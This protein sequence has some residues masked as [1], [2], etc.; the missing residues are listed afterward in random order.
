MSEW[1]TGTGCQ[2]GSGGR[3]RVGRTVWE[4]ITSGSIYCKQK[5]GDGPG[6]CPYRVVV[7]DLQVPWPLA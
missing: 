7:E 6:H 5:V 4:V 1:N 3:A 2:I